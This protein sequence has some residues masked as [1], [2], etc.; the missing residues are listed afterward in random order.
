MERTRCRHYQERQ[1]HRRREAQHGR[2]GVNWLTICDVIIPRCAVAARASG[3]IRKM[4]ELAPT[5]AAPA[6]AKAPNVSDKIRAH[7]SKCRDASEANEFGLKGY[8]DS[9]YK[10]Y[11]TCIVYPARSLMLRLPQNGCVRDVRLVL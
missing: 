6:A 8:W 7:L 11:G 1:E 5:P 4:A 2:G 10:E 3:G 9:F